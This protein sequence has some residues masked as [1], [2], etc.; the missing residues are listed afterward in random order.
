MISDAEMVLTESFKLVETDGALSLC[1]LDATRVENVIALEEPHFL[2]VPFEVEFELAVVATVAIVHDAHAEEV[3][4]C[5]K[6]LL[7]VPV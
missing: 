4:Q 3:D 1:R 2:L 5:S 6:V 7:H